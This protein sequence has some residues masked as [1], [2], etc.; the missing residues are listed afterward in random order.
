MS[1]ILHRIDDLLQKKGVLHFS[2]FEERLKKDDLPSQLKEMSI[3]GF[4][5]LTCST[6]TSTLLIQL[7]VGMRA[8]N[9]CNEDQPL[10]S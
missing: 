4:Q 10:V 6:I 3:L 1:P 5:P 9:N 7:F 8:V 2:W